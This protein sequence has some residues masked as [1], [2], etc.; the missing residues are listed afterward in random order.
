MRCERCGHP[1]LKGQSFIVFRSAR[2]NRRAERHV[3]CPTPREVETAHRWRRW[4]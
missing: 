4:R 3:A 1:I 2:L